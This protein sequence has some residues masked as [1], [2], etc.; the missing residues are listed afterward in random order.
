MP[1]TLSRLCFN[2]AGASFNELPGY[3]IPRLLFK[4]AARA[5]IA[6]INILLVSQLSTQYVFDGSFDFRSLGITVTG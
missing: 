6:N 4:V 5:E 1:T 2:V 3:S